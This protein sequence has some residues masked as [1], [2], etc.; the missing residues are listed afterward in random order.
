MTMRAA[1]STARG[2]CSTDWLRRWASPQA[3]PTA[4]PRHGGGMPENER[5]CRALL[6]QLDGRA[7]VCHHLARIEAVRIVGPPAAEHDD[8]GSRLVGGD[9]VDVDRVGPEGSGTPR[10]PIMPVAAVTVAP[11]RTPPAPRTRAVRLGD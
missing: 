10:I 6:R 1:A 5:Q 4:L 9:G 3:R 7:E 11:R 8:L 2:C